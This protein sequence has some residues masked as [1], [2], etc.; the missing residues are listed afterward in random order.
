MTRPP[1]P[2][3]YG[4]W[5]AS[6]AAGL[7][8]LALITFSV[9]L[10]LFMASKAV[11]KPGLAPKLAAFHEHLALSGLIATAVHGITLLGDHWLNPG[12]VGIAVPFVMDYKPLWTGL[13]ILSGHL[14]AILGLSFYFRK[15]IGNKRWRKLHRLTSLVYVL[16][17]AHTIGAGSDV[18]APWLQAA[19]LGSAAAVLFLLLLRVL[20]QRLDVPKTPQAKEAATT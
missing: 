9:L 16:A 2:P 20:P 7:V 13:G 4:G 14:A 6:R 11:R 8:A 12:P 5:L 17:L 15:R 1:D 18:K 19:L 3:E 10:G